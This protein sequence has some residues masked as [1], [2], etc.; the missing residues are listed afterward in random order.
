MWVVGNEKGPCLLVC[1]EQLVLVKGDVG[2]HCAYAII[3][4]I[5][6]VD[7][8]DSNATNSI[9]DSVVLV[10][11][12]GVKG[13]GAGGSHAVVSGAVVRWMCSVLGE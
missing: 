13:E 7:V 8:C 1:C 6:P 12:V 2:D 11:G 3:I 5:H 9:D 10:R 4:K